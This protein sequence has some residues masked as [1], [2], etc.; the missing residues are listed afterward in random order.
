MDRR[1]FVWCLPEYQPLLPV[2]W[3]ENIDVFPQTDDGLKVQTLAKNP[4]ELHAVVGVEN[5][6]AALLMALNVSG[7]IC[8]SAFQKK[9]QR[10]IFCL[11]TENRRSCF[12]MPVLTIVG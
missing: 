9:H 8:A 6:F 5:L 2:Y 11:C 10:L 3:P 12:Q 1:Y 7:S 4:R